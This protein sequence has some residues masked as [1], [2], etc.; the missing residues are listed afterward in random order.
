[1]NIIILADKYL[2]RMKSKGCVGLI[3]LQNRN[4]LYHQ[5]KILINKFPLSKIIYV[6]GFDNKR[7]LSYLDKNNELYKQFIFVHN[8]MYNEYNNAYS[9]SLVQEYFDDDLLIMFG[10]KI[11]SNST[12]NKFGSS[13]FSQIFID[14]NSQSKLGCVIDNNRIENICYDL[15]NRL[16]EIYFISKDQTKELKTLVSNP[17]FHNCFI[18]ELMNKIIDLDKIIIPH[19]VNKKT[20]NAI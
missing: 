9:L 4:I 18:F 20:S 7:L 15:D 3:K 6:Y 19:F 1:M 16:S 8:H 12:F 14:N 11:L 5:H 13:R 10:D 2:K 17:I